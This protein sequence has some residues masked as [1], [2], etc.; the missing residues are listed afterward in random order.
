M[1]HSLL[2]KCRRELKEVLVLR[3][4]RDTLEWSLLP[5]ALRYSH[6]KI[7][8]M[9]EDHMTQA[10]VEIAEIT[11]KINIRLKK[12]E[13][14][15]NRA[16]QIVDALDDERYRM[17]LTLYYLTLKKERRGSYTAR[18]LYSWEDVAGAMNYS[19]DHV[20]HLHWEA[21]GKIKKMTRQ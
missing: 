20:R 10:M 6:D 12:M 18:H 8:T 9:P 5:R 1:S 13:Y 7:E 11:E 14:R 3:E 21:I 16:Q 2:K 4:R 17:V 15:Q 19:Y